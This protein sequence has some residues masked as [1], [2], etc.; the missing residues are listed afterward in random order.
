METARSKLEER[1]GDFVKEKRRGKM[2]QKEWKEKDGSVRRVFVTY[3]DKG[4]I[5]EVYYKG[6][7][8]HREEGPAWIEY[9]EGNKVKCAYYFKEGK[10]HKEEGPA[11][12][13]FY[14]DGTVKK[15]EWWRDDRVH[16]DGDEPAITIYH[17]NGKIWM[18]MWC[19]NG[20]LERDFT[21]GPAYVVFN[22][23]GKKV[24]EMYTYP[25]VIK[26]INYYDGAIVE[27]VIRGGKEE[28]FVYKLQRREEF[29][30]FGSEA[31]VNFST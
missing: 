19:K 20:R 1:L 11:V 17:P 10:I 5:G 31:G 26:E 9:Y 3:D 16:R 13:W 2:F 4:F 23:K 30:L 24:T 7:V 18:M 21:K 6:D 8:K 15:E 12:V 28:V 22:E 29:G 25:D 14:A 27:V